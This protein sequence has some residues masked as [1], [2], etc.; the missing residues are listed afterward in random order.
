MKKAVVMFA[1]MSMSSFA[2]QL[3]GT[4]SEEHCGAKHADASEASIACVQKC[5]KGGSAPVFVTSDNKIL[6]ISNTSKV[7]NVL[8]HKVTVNG[9]VSGD[10]LTVKSVKE[11]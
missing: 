3:T 2:A 1:L 9:K 7:M 11:I 10:T 8:G 5:V 6:K 4:I